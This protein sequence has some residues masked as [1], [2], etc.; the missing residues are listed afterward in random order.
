MALLA[1]GQHGVVSRW[2]LLELGMSR[3]RIQ[4]RAARSQLHRLYRGVY[5]VGH[6]K[7]TLKGV[8][9]AAVLACGPDAAL[10]HRAGLG[11]W[12]V[13]RTESGLIDVTMPGRTGRRGPDDVRLHRSTLLREADVDAV[14]GI[15]VTSLAW[16]VVD[17]AG[18][19]HRQQLRS[20][21]EALERR[22]LYIGRELDE[23]LERA[24][25]RKG[26]KAVT[27]VIAEMTGPAPWLQS[28]LEA[29]FRE[30]I[31]GS[32][33]PEYEANVM[34]E[35]EVVD[36][37]W[38]KERVIVELDGYAFHKSRAR[39]EADRRRDAKLQVA[40][41]R[42]LRVT[43]ERLTNEPQAVLAEIRALLSAARAAWAAAGR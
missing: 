16:T 23:L 7:L 24:P 41:Y 5:A 12:D 25:N 39:F 26:V 15:P 10:S 1:G 28:E 11:L 33:L 43:Q 32:D 22:G 9:M 19:A 21:L 6:R 17:Y 29:I 31:R 14:D 36:A 8:W 37:L 2:Q 13:R 30:V 20:V 3:D 27:A 34:V 18:I 4:D 35:G 42:V 40:G 38:R